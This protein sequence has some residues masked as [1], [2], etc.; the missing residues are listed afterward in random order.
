MVIQAQHCLYSFSW[1]DINSLSHS[2]SWMNMCGQKFSFLQFCFLRLQL[3]YETKNSWN[4]QLT[5]FKLCA[6]LDSVTRSHTN[7]LHPA[8]CPWIIR[9]QNIVLSQLGGGWGV[10]VTLFYLTMAPKRRVVT[11]AILLSC[12]IIFAFF[13]CFCY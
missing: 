13:H 7:P 9:L 12:I 8:W 11:L 6:I 1:K 4:K 2:N 10:Q 3:K 5:S